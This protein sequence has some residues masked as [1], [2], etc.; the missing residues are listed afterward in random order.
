MESRIEAALKSLPVAVLGVD[1]TEADAKLAEFRATLI[2]LSHGNYLDVGLTDTDAFATLDKL[3][4]ELDAFARESPDVRVK[5]N[6]AAAAAQLEALQLQLDRINGGSAVR[7]GEG[8]LGGLDAGAES[9][10]LSISDVLLPAIALIGPAIAP[11]VASGVAGLGVLALGAKGLADNVTGTLGPAFNDL[12]KQAT[13]ALAP[14]SGPAISDIDSAL[15]KLQ[16][17]IDSVAGVVGKDIDQGAAWLNGSGIKSITSY[18]NEELPPANRLLAAGA[19]AVGEFLNSTKDQGAATLGTLGNVLD[20]FNDLQRIANEAPHV[21]GNASG[22]KGILQGLGKL[23]TGNEVG[24][25][26]QLT[27]VATGYVSEGADKLPGYASDF[28]GLF[29]NK[30]PKAPLPPA[31]SLNSEQLQQA[32]GGLDAGAAQINATAAS[33]GVLVDAYQ[34]AATAAQQNK[35]AEAASTLQMQLENNAAGLLWQ[36]LSGLGGD[37]LGVAQANTQFNTGLLTLKS[38]LQGN[39]EAVS[40][41][42]AAAL[43]N[44]AALQQQVSAAQQVYQATAQQTGS[45]DKAKAAYDA[46]ITS[47]E[48]ATGAT[49]AQKAAIIAYIDQIDKIPPVAQTQL[50]IDDAAALKVLQDFQSQM[51]AALNPKTPGITV[52]SEAVLRSASAHA[53]GGPLNEG[54]NTVGEAGIEWLYKSGSNVQVYNRH[55][56]SAAMPQAAPAGPQTIHLTVQSVLDGRVVAQSVT[57]HQTYNTS[58]R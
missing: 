24:G 2:G 39:H 23:A 4:G 1:S 51:A 13:S 49:G 16:P 34:E 48:N 37:A 46:S 10:G 56:I 30:K 20:T 32:T 38:T 21:S 22:G 5:V 47:I 45:T 50:D 58:R 42:T 29:S 44:Q 40:G 15:G 41:N 3:R 26:T 17:L 53:G 9:A 54:W 55:Q 19:Q 12:Q 52:T 11:A 43:A 18:I 8:A 28:I 36:A 14:F 6:T 33:Y 7:G 27:S 25:L 57:E 35:A 31:P